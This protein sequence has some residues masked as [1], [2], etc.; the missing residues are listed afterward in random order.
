VRTFVVGDIHGAYKALLQCFER[1]GFDREKDRLIA[2][3]DVC[4]GW[5]QVRECV[6]ELLKVK[7]LSYILGN[8]DAW[9]LSWAKT[10]AVNDVWFA[11]GGN[12]TLISYD[13]APMPPAHVDFFANA[14]R[15]LI[16]GQKVFVHA[17]FDPVKPMTDQ[18]PE[19]L[20]WDRK[21]IVEAFQKHNA[22]SSHKFGAF[23]EIF[24]GH[25]PTLI[26]H[27]DKPLHLCNVWAVDTGAG[28]SGRLTIMD[29]DTKEYW[30]SDPCQELYPDVKGRT[31]Y[32][33]K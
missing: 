5:T 10:G 24:L 7:N 2:L 28:W 9:T 23:T 21:L 18:D 8:H 4:D 29:V 30:Q 17:G 12:N 26:F 6:D 11:Q 15:Y 19:L 32:K 1:S 31:P 27:V 16:E 14:P 13:N 20:I 25:T 3:G 22:D 33:K